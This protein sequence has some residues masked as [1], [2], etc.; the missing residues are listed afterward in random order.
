[1]AS[2][3]TLQKFVGTLDSVIKLSDDEKRFIRRDE[4]GTITFSNVKNEIELV[5]WIAKEIRSLDLSH[6]PETDMSNADNYLSKAKEQLDRISSFTLDGNI[7]SERMSIEASL[8]QEVQNLV[9]ALGMWL[10]LLSLRA[11]RF[12]SLGAQVTDNIA[13]AEALLNQAKTQSQSALQEITEAVEAARAAAG[14]AGAAE[15]TEEFRREADAATKR[16]RTWLPAAGLFA[17]GAL[18][19]SVMLMAGFL[20]P[21]P[22][23]VWSAVYQLGG[24]AVAISVLLYAAIWSGRIVLANMNLASVNKHRAVSLQTLKAFHRA[25]GDPATKDA[26]VLEAARSVYENVPSGYVTRS[27]T[28]TAGSRRT[29]ELIKSAS[30]K[31]PDQDP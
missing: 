17:A 18:A 11:G 8:G 9:S 26:V 10:P 7:N 15:F 16:N 21:V 31:T 4:W 6:I 14:E 22:K 28:D 5:F 19:L 24:R 1:M 27:S 25:A 29:L 30:S 12:E 2:V 3:E 23:D 20:G 13:Q